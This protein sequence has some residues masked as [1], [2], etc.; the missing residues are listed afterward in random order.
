MRHV[1]SFSKRAPSSKLKDKKGERYKDIL[2][3]IA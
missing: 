1:L 3:L 2:V